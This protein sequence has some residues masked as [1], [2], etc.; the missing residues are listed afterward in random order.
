M[1]IAKVFLDLLNRPK[2]SCDLPGQTTHRFVVAVPTTGQHLERLSETVTSLLNQQAI[3]CG[4]ASVNVV[5][6]T[7]IAQVDNIRRWERDIGDLPPLARILVIPEETPG[8]YAA[9]STALSAEEGEVFCW[10]GV[11]DRYEPQAF[12]L[13][14]ENIPKRDVWWITTCIVGRRTD[15][16]I[17]R[18]TQPYR[19]RR[20]LFKRLV[21]GRILPSV[22]QESTFWSAS[23]NRITLEPMFS[24]FRL[25]GDYYLWTRFVEQMEPIILEAST[26][27][28]RWHGDNLSAEAREYWEEI[29]RWCGKRSLLGDLAGRIE[30]IFWLLPNRFKARFNSN[31]RRYKWPEGP[32]R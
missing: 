13:V 3:I 30:G 12:D 14:L 9:L 5:V 6:V 29:E 26:G 20:F 10:L 32:W 2:L 8:L 17:V 21:Y 16:A 7:P 31:Y 1:F 28:F 24:S 19:Y 27:S 11:G 18:V 15:G 4:R 25:A 23:L 22:Q